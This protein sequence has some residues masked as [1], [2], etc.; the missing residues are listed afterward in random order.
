[1]LEEL[2][3]LDASE[4]FPRR[5]NAKEVLLSQIREEFIF[6]EA[7]GTAKM[8]GRDYE[9]REPTL[10][11]EQTVRSEDLGGGL[12]CE[13]G[14]YESTES[15]DDAEVRA[16]FWSIEG[17]FICRH[18]NEPRVIS[19][20]QLREKSVRDVKTIIFLASIFQGPIPGPMLKRAD[21]PQAVNKLLLFKKQVENTNPYVPQHLRFR[22]RPIEERE[23]LELQWKRC[24]WIS[25]SQSSSSSSTGWTGNNY[26]L[27]RCGQNH[28]DGFQGVSLKGNSDSFVKRRE[29]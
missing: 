3:N 17:D 13:L 11:R 4:I 27:S 24:G 21:F 6:P 29:V 10:R 18:H 23:R 1:M 5:I 8:S 12:E 25:W 2:E 7:D 19:H 15:T 28:S 26:V 9:F 14:E 16:D 20:I 22:Q